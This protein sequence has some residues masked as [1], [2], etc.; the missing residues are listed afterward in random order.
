[1][2]KST[3]LHVGWISNH[4]R[5]K[6]FG[7]GLHCVKTAQ[8]EK[9][10]VFLARFA[11][12]EIMLCSSYKATKGYLAA[13]QTYLFVTIPLDRTRSLKPTHRGP[14]SKALPKK[15]TLTVVAAT[16]DSTTRQSGQR[17]LHSSKN[18]NPDTATLNPAKLMLIL[19]AI[20]K[21]QNTKPYTSES[22]N[23]N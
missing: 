10:N 22:G 4:L 11:A 20:P 6:N 9:A 23:L 8:P 14:E 2:T 15:N 3:S 16:T 1:M 13:S 19:T 5:S 18:M 17:N 21:K 12:L 7:E